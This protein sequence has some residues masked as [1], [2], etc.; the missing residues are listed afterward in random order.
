MADGGVYAR[1]GGKWERV[2]SGGGSGGGIDVESERANQ[3]LQGDGAA[4]WQPGMALEVVDAV[5][6]DDDA[7]YE[8]GDVVFVTGPGD[9]GS[10]GVGGGK[11]LQVVQDE[12]DQ[13][14][15]IVSTDYQDAD[16]SVTITPISATS[17]I[18]VQVDASIYIS[19]KA[20]ADITGHAQLMRN[21]VAI[22][23]FGAVCRVRAAT[24]TS[25][26][27][28]LETRVTLSFIDVPST[29]SPCT[30]SLQA[31]TKSTNDEAKLICPGPSGRG[32]Y[33]TF[34]AMEVSQ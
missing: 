28:S 5:P 3:L 12:G 15:D 14:T 26:Q 30:Y 11:V 6:A 19:H 2:G 24:G 18:L 22:K 34:T 32:S 31:T 17:K 4:G 8:I 23:D 1:T 25:S 20:T 29:T 16:G 13:P 27:V 21:G 7:G 10:P 9:G 33:N